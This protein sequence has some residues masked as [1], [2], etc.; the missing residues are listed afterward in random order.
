[1]NDTVVPAKLMQWLEDCANMIPDP[2]HREFDEGSRETARE[3]FYMLKEYHN[4][5]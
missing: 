4:V 1:M 3:F 5:K 2:E